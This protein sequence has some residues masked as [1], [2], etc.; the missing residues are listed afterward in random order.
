[1]LIG[2]TG[3]SRMGHFDFR[4]ESILFLSLPIRV[5]LEYR[6]TIA[7][8]PCGSRLGKGKPVKFEMF[9]QSLTMNRIRAE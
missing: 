8:F 7:F 3:R 5:R 9:L 2:M 6:G 1:M 4:P